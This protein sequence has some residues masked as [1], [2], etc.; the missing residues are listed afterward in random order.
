MAAQRSGAVTASTVFSATRLDD[1]SHD[2][3]GVEVARRRGRRGRQTGAGRVEVAGVDAVAGRRSASS[4]S[5]RPAIATVVAA[6]VAAGRPSSAE[7][8]AGGDAEPAP[9]ARWRTP[10]C[11]GVAVGPSLESSPWRCRTRRRDASRAGG[12]PRTWSSAQPAAAAAPRL[13][14][15]EADEPTEQVLVSRCSSTASASRSNVASSTPPGASP[16]RAASTARVLEQA[17]DGGGEDAAAGPH[18]S[19]VVGAA[20]SAR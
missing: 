17:V 10:G 12:S 11:S 13:A 18:R 1:G 9:T 20:G 3:G 8:G 5:I 7:H 16:N 19:V 4:A 2:L 14:I 6:S 15:I